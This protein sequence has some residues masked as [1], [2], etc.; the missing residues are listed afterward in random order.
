MNE[1]RIIND[2]VN[3]EARASQAKPEDA[4][5]ILELLI[6]TAKW[7]RSK[8]SHQWSGLLEG[9]DNHDTTGSISRGNVFMCKH[10]EFLAGI[11][12]LLPEPSEWDRRLWGDEGHEG[13]IYLH[14]LAISRDHA[15]K[16]LGQ[17]MMRWAEE[18]IRFQGKDRIRLDCIADNPVLNDFYSRI[19]YEFKGQ[20][21]GGFNRFEKLL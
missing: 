14:R 6:Q 4:A 8:G 19:G 18:G 7:L 13:A 17:D 10:G 3:Q 1:Y 5:A 12:I 11:M 21:P 16:S 2:R 20:A 9:R 15:G